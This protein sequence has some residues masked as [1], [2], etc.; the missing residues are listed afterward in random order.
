MNELNRKPSCIPESYSPVKP[1]I[2]NMVESTL[3]SEKSK[4]LPYECVI[5]PKD[6]IA[7][8]SGEKWPFSNV[9]PAVFSALGLLYGRT[10]RRDNTGALINDDIEYAIHNVLTGY[11]FGLFY[12]KD[13]NYLSMAA[14]GFSSYHLNADEYTEDE[15]AVIIKDQVY[16]GN[17]VHIDASGEPFDYL[18]WGYKNDG[19]ILLGYKFE[20]GNDM[21]NCSYD[22]DNPIEFDTL[23]KRLNKNDI[24]KPDK[25]QTGG[26]TLIQPDG[27]RL[28]NEII[29][30]Q[31]LTD[32]YRMLTQVKPNPEMDFARVHFGY[33]QAIYDEWIRQIEEMEKEDCIQFF[34]TSPIFPHF[35]ALYENRLQLLRFLKHWNIQINNEHLNKA[36]EI[37]EQLKS[38]SGDAATLTMDGD[39]NPMRNASNHEKRTFALDALKKCRAFELEIAECIKNVI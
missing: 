29:Y 32:G 22:L 15:I 25:G 10:E 35:I 11:A 19:D 4:Q 6:V 37:C 2:F 34:Y 20:H 24:F 18:I 30:R 14:Y 16:R 5:K 23:V 13:D 36:I 17:C 21:L 8:F 3:R 1:E 33:G 31:A 7:S 39:W 27:D 9:E 38:I 26:I 12:G 28:D